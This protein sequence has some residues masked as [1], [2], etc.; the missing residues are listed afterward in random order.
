MNN[1]V[2]K[3]KVISGSNIG[4]NVFTST[5][6][7]I[8]SDSMI[9][10]TFQHK[11]LHKVISCAMTINK[12]QRQSLNNVSIY[13]LQSI[14][15]HKQIYVRIS[16]VTSHRDLKRI[17]NDNEGHISNSTSHIVYKDVFQNSA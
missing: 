6:S 14:F 15:L 8:S 7:L 16:R 9:R 12:S 5:L 2:L 1:Y 4:Q 13:L 3:A 17:I 10:F 11:Q